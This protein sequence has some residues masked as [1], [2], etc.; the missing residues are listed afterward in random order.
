MRQRKQKTLGSAGAARSACSVRFRRQWGIVE[1]LQAALRAAAAVLYPGCVLRTPRCAW[2]AVHRIKNGSARCETMVSFERRAS[3]VRASRAKR[4]DHDHDVV[5]L[6]ADRAGQVI[7][8]I[9]VPDDV[10][11]VVADVALL[12]NLLRVVRDGWHPRAHVIHNLRRVICVVCDVEAVTEV[13]DVE[14][15]V[16]AQVGPQINLPPDARHEAL[17]RR[18]AFRVVKDLALIRLPRCDVQ[19]S[20]LD[21]LARQ[22]AV[23]ILQVALARCP[24]LL[25]ARV[26]YAIRMPRAAAARKDPESSRHVVGVPRLAFLRR[27]GAAQHGRIEGI[28]RLRQRLEQGPQR[29]VGFVDEHSTV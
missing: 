23:E 8:W 16:K 24:L 2:T 14:L 3:R 7:S 21:A 28:H 13:P 1:Q 6:G 15:A 9:V 10:N 19:H 22:E 5:E 18:T 17:K 11:V 12:C 20:H 29:V 27:T 25:A 26:Q 4:S